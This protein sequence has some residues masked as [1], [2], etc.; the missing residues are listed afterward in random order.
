MNNVTK[1]QFAGLIIKRAS[2]LHSDFGVQQY[3]PLGKRRDLTEEEEEEVDKAKKKILPRI[4]DSDQD[5]ISADMASP[6]WAAGG[7][8]ALGGLAGAMLGS[9]MGI[10]IGGPK[11]NATMQGGM[12]LGGALGLGAGGLIGALLAYHARKAENA[13][14]EERMRRL[15]EGANRRDMKSDPVVQAEMN[16][17][18]TLAAARIQAGKDSRW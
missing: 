3:M 1:L 12:N 11:R 2:Q 15:P 13:T 17:A 10:T 16:R 7:G 18:A 14:L 4:F 5:P 6:G 8:G 9:A